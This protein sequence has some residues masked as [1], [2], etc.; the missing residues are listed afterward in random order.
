MK[1]NKIIGIAIAIIII[2][3]LIYFLV[4]KK[5]KP[6]DLTDDEMRDILL[7][8]NKIAGADIEAMTRTQ[9][10]SEIKAGGYKIS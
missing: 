6:E 4:I 2:G 8:G 1:A 3:G 10:I 9:L 5:K 7:K